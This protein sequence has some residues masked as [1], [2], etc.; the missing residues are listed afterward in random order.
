MLGLRVFTVMEY[1]FFISYIIYN[2]RKNKKQSFLIASV[3][4]L[5]VIAIIDYTLFPTNQFDSLPSGI[6]AI[7]GIFFCIYSLF[8]LIKK[9]TTLFLYQIP[10]FWF[11]SGMFLFYSGTLFLFLLSQQNFESPSFASTFVII[12]SSFS[13]LR[14]LLFSIAFSVPSP[15]ELEDGSLF[16]VT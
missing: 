15:K 13:I 16:E 11:V 7:L 1:A 12:N 9:T 5:F 8:L 2:L 6:A 10:F 4:I 3:P 14:N